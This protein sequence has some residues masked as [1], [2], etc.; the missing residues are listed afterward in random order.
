[1]QAAETETRDPMPGSSSFLFR[2][3]LWLTST[4]VLFL[5]SGIL[6]AGALPRALTKFGYVEPVLKNAEHFYA[7][8]NPDPQ[9]LMES[10]FELGKTGVG[11]IAGGTFVAIC[12]LIFVIF[13]RVRKKPKE[14]ESRS[15]PEADRPPW[16][17]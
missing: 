7:K 13:F 3:F 12:L 9:Q 4:L 10:A 8:L 6:P 1:M 15:L 14:G 16:A 5:C 11:L 17:K 2:P